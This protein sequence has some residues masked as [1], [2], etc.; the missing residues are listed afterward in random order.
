MPPSWGEGG[1]VCPSEASCWS[2]MGQ[3]L[4]FSHVSLNS[5]PHIVSVQNLESFV[6][7]KASTAF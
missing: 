6:A 1:V 5:G 2:C 3:H 4:A 7:K